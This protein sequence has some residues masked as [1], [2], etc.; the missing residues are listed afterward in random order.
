MG[1]VVVD[2][3][4]EGGLRQGEAVLRGE[5]GVELCGAGSGAFDRF[6]LEAALVAQEGEVVDGEF[7]G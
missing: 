4:F 3:D 1:E 5:L 6:L 7:N 2:G